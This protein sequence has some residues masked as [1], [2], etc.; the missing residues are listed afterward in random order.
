MASQAPG[1]RLVRV[2]CALDP[3]SR[4]RLGRGGA[5][6]ERTSLPLVGIAR[7]R[8]YRKRLRQAKA[9]SAPYLVVYE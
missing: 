5:D 2:C 4:S 1:P 8:R 6:G 3:A 7:L 9:C